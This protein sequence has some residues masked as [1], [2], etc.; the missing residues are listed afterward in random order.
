MGHAFLQ[1]S[2]AFCP[3][4]TYSCSYPSGRFAVS[5][6]LWH[7]DAGCLQHSPLHLDSV[8]YFSTPDHLPQA[9]EAEVARGETGLALSLLCSVSHRCRPRVP[10]VLRA[11]G[12]RSWEDCCVP[13]CPV[14]LLRQWHCWLGVEVGVKTRKTKIPKDEK[15]YILKL[16]SLPNYLKN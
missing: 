3:N 1:S 2:D 4:A 5:P 11:F 16:L 12:T 8:L 9:L 15:N 14:P 7:Y 6:G 10:S 13:L